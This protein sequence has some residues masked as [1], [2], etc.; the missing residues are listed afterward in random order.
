MEWYERWFN[1]DYLELYNHRDQKEAAEQV[2]FLF[3]LNPL[4][5][6]GGD[7]ICLDVACG[8][9][10]HLES[11]I[12]KGIQAFG[13]DL[14]RILLA[15]ATPSVLPKVAVADMRSLPI[16]SNKVDLITN[17]FTSF[18]YFK[19]KAEELRVITE[20]SRLL[21]DGGL[22]FMDLVN[23]D[24]VVR[25][26]VPEKQFEFEGGTA[27]VKK[28][29]YNVDGETRV[30]KVIELNKVTGQKVVHTEDVHLFTL[31][32]ITH[33]LNQAG[34]NILEAYGESKGEVIT[35]TKDSP[36]LVVLAQKQ[37]Q[38]II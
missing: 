25:D 35:F 16:L 9:G 32:E 3:S 10:R 21:R 19:S 8:T 4:R 13:I 5:V 27:L 29:I 22:L 1:Q 30:K 38:K 37:R 7:K 23:L 36:R 28:S 26:L 31:S 33:L 14:S 11:L 6:W 20:F 17:F 15:N 34:I 2:N 12:E 24:P 18:G